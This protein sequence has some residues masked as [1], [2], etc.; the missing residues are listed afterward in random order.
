MRWLAAGNEEG[1]EQSV[2]TVNS[3][4]EGRS[5]EKALES[6]FLLQLLSKRKLLIFLKKEILSK[7]KPTDSVNRKPI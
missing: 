3:H 5:P 4:R 6:N 7:R 2:R 1:R